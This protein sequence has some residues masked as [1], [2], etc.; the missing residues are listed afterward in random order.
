MGGSSQGLIVLISPA[1]QRLVP[2]LS[3]YTSDWDKEPELPWCPEQQMLGRQ[4]LAMET[5]EHD[6]FLKSGIDRVHSHAP[7]LR[8]SSYMI[9][10]TCKYVLYCNILYISMT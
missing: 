3:F 7:F 8:L 1:Q 9:Y 10:R 5:F 4:T 2:L 6:V